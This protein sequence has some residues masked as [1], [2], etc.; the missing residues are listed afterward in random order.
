MDRR[1]FLAS[2]LTAVPLAAPLR[3]AAQP[4][5]GPRDRA[6]LALAREQVARADASLWRRDVA[7]VVDFGLHSGQPRFHIVNLEA[8]TV[9]S[10]LVAHGSGSDPEHDGWLNQYSN[11]VD[12]WATS[13]GAYVTWEWYEGMYGTSMRL[14][15]LDPDNSNVFDR[16]IV[17]HAAT[18]ATSVHLAR[19]G[20]LGRSNGCFAL[21]PQE[22]PATL[23]QLGGGRL[24]YADSLGIGADGER[25]IAPPQPPVDFESAIAQRRAE[26]E[27]RAAERVTDPAEAIPPVV[28][29]PIDE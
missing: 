18:Y 7:A 11:L 19:W 9:H 3:L 27:Q 8:G 29:P 23:Y 14:S 12:S 2:A 26:A 24:I 16:A 25:V 28:M 22:L 21:D 4:A 15:G 5:P 6:L 10:Q 20:K 17:M 13:R 1:R